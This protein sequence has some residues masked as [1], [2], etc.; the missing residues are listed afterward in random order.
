[1]LTS[2]CSANALEAGTT[3]LLTPVALC[4]AN[5]AATIVDMPWALRFQF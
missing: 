2:L 3:T 5:G 4:A 1:M